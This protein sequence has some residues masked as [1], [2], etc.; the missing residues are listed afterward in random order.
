MV[1]T[2]LG[3]AQKWQQWYSS[4]GERYRPLSS[5]P[6]Q[7]LF[8]IM[9]SVT[10]SGIE[11]SRTLRS[12]V[13]ISASLVAV[14]QSRTWGFSISSQRE[15]KSDHLQGSIGCLFLPMH[16]PEAGTKVVF[17]A[18]IAQTQAQHNVILQLNI[19]YTSS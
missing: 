8:G 4:L 15:Q 9:G 14:N 19:A 12:R 5:P 18:H 6:N 7:S 1:E 3:I 17:D 11:S 13:S 16:R 2:K 10:S